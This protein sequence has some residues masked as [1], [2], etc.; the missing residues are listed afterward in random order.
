M[1]A[2]AVYHHKTSIPGNKQLSVSHRIQ[3]WT[4]LK[5]EFKLIRTEFCCV[6]FISAEGWYARVSLQHE[7]HGYL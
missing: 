7:N 5:M 1:T 4:E 3:L 2:F 6:K